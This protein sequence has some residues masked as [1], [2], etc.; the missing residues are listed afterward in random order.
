MGT[1]GDAT[2]INSCR[3]LTPTGDFLNATGALTD[4]VVPGHWKEGFFPFAPKADYTIVYLDDNL[5]IE[6]DCTQVLWITNYCIH[7]LAKTP[8]ISQADTQKLMDVATQ[9]KLTN[10]NL[11]YQ[12]TLQDKC[13]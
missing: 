10:Q 2:A 9:L 11:P 12:V 3:K 4:E 6:Y 7:L 8:T 13:W 5:A 1:I